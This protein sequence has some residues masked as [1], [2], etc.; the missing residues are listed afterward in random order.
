LFYENNTNFNDVCV[1]INSEF[2][3]VQLYRSYC[4]PFILYT[5]EAIPLTRS[6]IK[7]LDDCIN[8][9]LLRKFLKYVTTTTL[10]LLDKYVICLILEIISRRCHAICQL[11]QNCKLVTIHKNTTTGND[12]AGVRRC[13]NCYSHPPE[14]CWL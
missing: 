2:V 12:I 10:M 3:S 8:C 4:L 1:C 6:S 7:M 11:T 14:P 13:F 9:V 5:T